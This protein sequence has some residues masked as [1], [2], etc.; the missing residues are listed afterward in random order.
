MCCVCSCP[1][2][3]PG[4]SLLML[5]LGSLSLQPQ[6]TCKEH[7][8]RGSTVGLSPSPPAWDGHLQCL[9]DI[10]GQGSRYGPGW[11]R[12]GAV[13]HREIWVP[14]GTGHG[15]QSRCSPKQDQKMSKA[16]NLGPST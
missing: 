15:G 1:G 12:L 11:L 9:G 8:S 6:L 7:C 14:T 4:R 10:C 5:S 13:L 3:Y 2:L 16:L